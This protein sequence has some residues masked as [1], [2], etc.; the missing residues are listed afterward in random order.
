MSTR[1]YS[2]V[3]LVSYFAV[4]VLVGYGASIQP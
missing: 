4:M 3:I 1:F 2:V